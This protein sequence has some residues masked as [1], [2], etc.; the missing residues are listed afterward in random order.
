MWRKIK[1]TVFFMWPASWSTEKSSFYYPDINLFW[2]DYAAVD[3]VVYGCY[4]S[5]TTPG[6]ITI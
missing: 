3:Y 5:I 1:T 4:S 2:V 6:V